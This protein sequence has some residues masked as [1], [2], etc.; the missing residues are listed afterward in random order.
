MFLQRIAL[1]VL[2]PWAL[3][4]HIQ[5]EVDTQLGHLKLREVSLSMEYLGRLL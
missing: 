3:A 2:R 4:V 1:L 5:L